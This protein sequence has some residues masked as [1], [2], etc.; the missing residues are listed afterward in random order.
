[1]N[2]NE[3]N[4]EQPQSTQ[5]DLF[6]LTATAPA[7][8]PFAAMEHSNAPSCESPVAPPPSTNAPRHP[9]PGA[10]VDYTV[11]AAEDAE[12]GHIPAES[13]AIPAQSPASVSYPA[14]KESRF[15]SISANQP[16]FRPA[17]APVPKP[18]LPPSVGQK[19]NVKVDVPVPPSVDSSRSLGANL[20]MIRSRLGRKIEDVASE[21]RIR[22][23]FI[24]ELEADTLD[25]PIVYVSAY[26]RKLTEIYNV[27]EDDA[28][29]L[30]DMLHSM[31]TK[32]EEVAE[33]II[34]N[35]DTTEVVDE[36]EAKRV[37]R[38]FIGMAVSA[39]VVFLLLVWL[40]VALCLRGSS[41]SSPAETVR[42]ANGSGADTEAIFAQGGSSVRQQQPRNLASDPLLPPDTS[43]AGNLLQAGEHALD[44][45]IMPEMPEISVLKMSKKAAVRDNL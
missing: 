13:A 43:A 28:R 5:A 30:M 9:V 37:K 4:R 24:Q 39:A 25:L 44:S 17:S 15:D 3:L 21:T 33:A 2:E 22:I 41:S 8:H 40:I 10:V 38:L 20:Y 36:K 12:S 32:K 23:A 11:P 35:V 29:L 7:E 19:K 42:T 31:F 1:M 18:A 27:P 16:D 45:L 14:E 26:V 34:K 6:D